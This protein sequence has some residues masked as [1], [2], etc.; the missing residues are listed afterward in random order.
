MANGYKKIFKNK[1]F[2]LKFLK[3]LRFIP[4]SIMLKIEY[5]IKFH[6]K[7]NLKNPKSFNE[8]LQWLKIHNRKDIY[9]MMVDKYAVKNYVAGIIGT[10]YIIPTIGVWDKFEDIDFEGL[11]EKFVLKCNHD[12]GSVIVCKDKSKFDYQKAKNV[13][14]EG[15]KRNGYYAGRE[16][17]Y[18][19]VK[20][21]ILAEEFVEDREN[22][23]LPVYKIFCFNG[24]PRIIQTIQNDK[25]PNESVDYF[26]IEW[27]LL[28]IRQDYPNSKK[29]FSKP[30]RL[31]EMLNFAKKLSENESFIRVDFYVANEKIYFSEFTFFTDSGFGEFHPESWDEVMG[32]WLTLPEIN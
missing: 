17:P 11:P 21:R 16:W 27:N 12:S 3:L 14:T 28:P 30:E 13:L 18:K 25:Q 32:E 29:P 4:D 7:L 5:R 1:K 2:R 22:E 19:N 15:L 24:Q 20:A 6:K 9:T 10:E 8:K 31:E 23:C 26:D